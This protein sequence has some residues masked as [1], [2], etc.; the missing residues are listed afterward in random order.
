M[1]KDRSLVI[2]II[3]IFV[4]ACVVGVVSNNAGNGNGKAAAYNCAVYE[5]RA[6]YYAIYNPSLGSAYAK[7]MTGCTSFDS[8]AYTNEINRLNAQTN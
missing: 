3:G 6:N 1:A 8:T 2:A 4:L 5:A 7:A